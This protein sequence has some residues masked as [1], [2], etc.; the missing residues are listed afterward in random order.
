MKRKSGVLYIRG[1]ENDRD[2][3]Y[4]RRSLV[5]MGKCGLIHMHLRGGRD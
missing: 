3:G 1:K 2:A 5:T 4:G